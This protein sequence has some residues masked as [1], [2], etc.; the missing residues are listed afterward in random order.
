MEKIRMEKGE[1][2]YNYLKSVHMFLNSVRKNAL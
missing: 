2:H 1:T